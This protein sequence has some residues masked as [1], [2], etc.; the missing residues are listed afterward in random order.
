MAFPTVPAPAGGSQS[1]MSSA[2][3][4]GLLKGYPELWDFLTTSALPDGSTRLTGRLSV[5]FE[6]GVL[7]VSLTDDQTRQYVCMSG[8]RLDDLL[9]EIELRLADASLPW[10]P[11]FYE[12]RVKKRK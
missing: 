7:K 8:R 12:P 3:D 2:L 1:S 5:S 11:S 4:A 9:T 10:K 6:S